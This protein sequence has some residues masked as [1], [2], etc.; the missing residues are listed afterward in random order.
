MLTNKDHVNAACC[1]SLSLR[2]AN[3]MD[4]VESIIERSYLYR[5]DPTEWMSPTIPKAEKD[6]ISETLCF[7]VIYNSG[8]RTKYIN[9][10]I[11]ELESC[12]D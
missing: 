6:Q 12:H 7:L 2:Q 5:R 4:C 11:L 9:P 8:Q 3:E 10:V 1:I